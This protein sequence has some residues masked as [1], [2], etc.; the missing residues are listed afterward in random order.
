M[1][2]RSPARPSR[3]VDS[4]AGPLEPAIVVR[5]VASNSIDQKQNLQ[6]VKDVNSS[7]ASWVAEAATFSNTR[8]FNRS[9]SG[10]DETAPKLGGWSRPTLTPSRSG[11]YIGGNDG[12]CGGVISPIVSPVCAPKS[13]SKKVVAIVDEEESE[14]N[15]CEMAGKIHGND[16]GVVT[17]GAL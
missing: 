16:R 8:R 11:G 1:S 7:P 2:E 12:G 13:R 15:A 4:D 14:G 10:A 6:I 9:T 3:A 5:T 17:N